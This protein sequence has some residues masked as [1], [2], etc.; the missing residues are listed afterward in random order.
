MAT[1]RLAP[2]PAPRPIP[3]WSRPRVRFLSPLAN[4][5]RTATSR[6]WN[7]T[8]KDIGALAATGADFTSMTGYISGTLTDP[9]GIRQLLDSARESLGVAE[10]LVIS[11]RS[12]S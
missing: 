5:C 3:H 10:R 6:T 2:L 11:S 1:W 4:K 8:D 12:S 7:W 9:E